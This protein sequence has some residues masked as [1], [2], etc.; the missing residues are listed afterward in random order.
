MEKDP[1]GAVEFARKIV[2]KAKNKIEVEN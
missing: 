1:R 2:M